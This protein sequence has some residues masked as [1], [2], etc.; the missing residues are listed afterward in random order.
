MIDGWVTVKGQP[1]KAT[2]YAGDS[3]GVWFIVDPDR[4]SSP[5]RKAGA[6]TARTFRPA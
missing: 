1:R 5:W 4:V 2:W 3:G 6:A